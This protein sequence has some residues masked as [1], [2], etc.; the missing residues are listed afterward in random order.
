MR[1]YVDSCFLV[2][3]LVREAGTGAAAAEFRR[4][5]LPRLFFLPLHE[6]EVE[7]A[8]R[9]RAFHQNRTSA[10]RE[11]RAISREMTAAFSRLRTWQ[12]RGLFRD[13]ASDWD[14][15]LQRARHI[16]SQHTDHLGSRAIDVLHVA[17]A[18]NLKTEC[19]LTTDER[20]AALAKVLGLELVLVSDED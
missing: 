2:K 20:Q 13:V 15:A 11:R 16:S 10:S 4:L 3:L 6:L 19:F 1:V 18:L 8:I 14:L 12:K 9:Q 5:G 7:N 17:F